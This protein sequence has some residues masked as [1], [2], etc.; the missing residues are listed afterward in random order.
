MKLRVSIDNYQLLDLFKDLIQNID[1][2]LDTFYRAEGPEQV[3]RLV[4]CCH[5]ISHQNSNLKEVF[6]FRYRDCVAA[7]K[8]GDKNF[9]GNFFKKL[10]KYYFIFYYYFH[11]FYV[12]I[13]YLNYYHL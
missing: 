1:S 11:Y 4:P 5:C 6:M 9:P 8:E 10:K 7:L 13:F 2:L 3:N 12:I